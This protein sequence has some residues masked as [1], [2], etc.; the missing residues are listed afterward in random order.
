LAI[1]R[2]VMAI[3]T[4]KMI[5]C[6]NGCERAEV[7]QGVKKDRR[8][9]KCRRRK[10][11]STYHASVDIPAIQ[12]PQ[13]SPPRCFEH[14]VSEEWKERKRRERA[15]GPCAREGPGVQPVTAEPRSC[16][17]LADWDRGLVRSVSLFAGLVCITLELKEC[18]YSGWAANLV[19]IERV[20]W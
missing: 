20:P 19:Q 10:I 6:N 18:Q 11:F 2:I 4:M 16:V 1:S 17:S 3:S 5:V 9:H 15:G 8:L 14:G 7:S 12:S 13:C